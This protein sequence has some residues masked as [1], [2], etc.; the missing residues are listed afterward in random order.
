MKNKLSFDEQ[1]KQTFEAYEANVPSYLWDRINK[2]INRRKPFFFWLSHNKF[3][4][5]TL[6]IIFLGAIYF[7]LPTDMN[8]NLSS[9]AKKNLV[10]DYSAGIKKE[11]KNENFKSEPVSKSNNKTQRTTT[12]IEV[13]ASNP[14]I[15]HFV[16]KEKNNQPAAD[17]I[18]STATIQ[19]QNV[20]LGSLQKNNTPEDNIETSASS[21][22]WTK[23]SA[24]N[25]RN[26][27]LVSHNKDLLGFSLNPQLMNVR[28][29]FNPSV[30]ML[31]K[32]FI[33]IPCPTYNPNKSKQYFDFYSSG[34]FIIRQFSDTPNSLYL[35]K[36]K[37][38]N[39]ISSAFSL[40]LRYTKLFKNGINIRGGFNFSQINEKFTFTQGNIIQII[41]ETNAAGDTIRSY[42]TEST[43][44]K[45]THNRYVSFDIPL[46]VGFEKAINN[47][48]INLNAG[49]LMNLTSQYRGDILDKNF[50]PV[51]INSSISENQY[52]LKNNIGIGCLGAVSLY[53]RISDHVKLLTEP[54]FRY[55]LSPMNEQSGAFKQQYH[56]AGIKVGVR[57]DLQ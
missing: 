54:Y 41:Y 5:F 16:E 49:V 33:N 53:Y 38:G 11:S 48:E 9:S 18:M 42:Q 47:W 8:S 27:A 57:Y 52:R 20:N 22:T 36:R 2:K 13:N 31:K 19:K 14:G 55:N 1:V 50:Q 26:P 6:L 24:N 7:Y 40:G 56:T 39:T 51:A 46:T 25:L 23:G 4:L 43:R 15:D 3:L 44:Y 45:I 34:D 32:R 37:E 12:A 10:Y 35:E 30:S 21:N 28:S 17:A 29:Q